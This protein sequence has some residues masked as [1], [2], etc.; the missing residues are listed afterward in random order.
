MDN[1]SYL[2]TMDQENPLSRDYAHRD[3]MHAHLVYQL[4]FNQKLVLSDSQLLLSPNLRTLLRDNSFFFSTLNAETLCVMVREVGK[5]QRDLVDLHERFITIGKI[6]KEDYDGHP[7]GLR[8]YNDSDILGLLSD[9]IELDSW[10]YEQISMNF[11]NRIETFIQGGPYERTFGHQHAKVIIDNLHEYEVYRRK[12]PQF[13]DTP[14]EVSILGRDVFMGPFQ[15][16]LAERGITLTDAQDTMIRQGAQALFKMNFPDT[17]GASTIFDPR[18]DEEFELLGKASSDLR[19]D[20]DRRTLRTRLRAARF[21]ECLKGMDAEDVMCL[22]DLPSFSRLL[23]LRQH[24][25]NSDSEREDLEEALAD[26]IINIEERIFR[27]H[28]IRPDSTAAEEPRSLQWFRAGRNALMEVSESVLFVSLS[29]FDPGPLVAQLN[30]CL[31]F[32]LTATEDRLAA[33][34]KK[35]RQARFVE[36][37]HMIEKHHKGAKEIDQDLTPTPSSKFNKSNTRCG[38]IS[39]I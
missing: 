12:Q 11:Q 16:Y 37:Q 3:M 1:L 23:E 21:V 14:D 15:S 36:T 34:I 25:N 17:F 31:W 13:E 18:D 19:P 29:D 30:S 38:A 32:S 35:D 5:E 39:R 24:S 6:K 22:R 2:L 26:H 9:K 8:A 7:N 20:D 28:G 10:N 4:L 27:K 33:D